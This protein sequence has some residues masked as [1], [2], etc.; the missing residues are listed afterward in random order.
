MLAEITL[1]HCNKWNKRISRPRLRTVPLQRSPDDGDEGLEPADDEP[2]PE[3]A[4]ILSEEVQQ[5]MRGCKSA[6]QRDVLT[7]RLQGYTASEISR[8]LGCS[9]RTVYRALAD[10]RNGL[11]ER[12]DTLLGAD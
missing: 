9:E 6:L 8:K 4:A 5:L 11:R 2:T 10:A 7:L 1:R 12:L 3:E